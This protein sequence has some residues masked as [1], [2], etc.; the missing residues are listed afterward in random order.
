MITYKDGSASEKGDVIGW[1]VEDGDDFTT[2]TFIGVV[3][4]QGVLYLGGG[5]DFGEGIGQIIPFEEVIIQAEDNDPDFTGVTYL[6][7]VSDLV[8]HVKRFS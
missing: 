6:G 7:K 1:C 4:Q 8:N 5:I 2:W 3:K